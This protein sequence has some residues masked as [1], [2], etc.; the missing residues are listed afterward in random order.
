MH[1]QLGVHEVPL[2][3]RPARPRRR[4]RSRRR[5]AAAA[6]GSAPRPAPAA[7]VRTHPHDRRSRPGH[8]ALDPQPLHGVEV[9]ARPRSG[10]F[11]VMA[12]V[13]PVLQGYA[14]AT[15]VRTRPATPGRPTPARGPPPGR[16]ASLSSAWRSDTVRPG[17]STDVVT[18]SSCHGHRSEQIHREPAEHPGRAVLDRLEGSTEQCRRW[19]AVLGL[20]APRPGRGRRGAESA[21]VERLVVRGCGGAHPT[22]IATRS[23]RGINRFQVS[24]PRLC[25][26]LAGPR[27]QCWAMPL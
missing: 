17:R 25:I 14:E 26:L 1:G 22:I 4:M 3:R 20:L 6:A 15:A 24:P 5:R 8:R 12:V 7:R 16:T 21:G 10:R 18:A 11:L 23:S 19:A 9:A 2:G 13:R 27:H